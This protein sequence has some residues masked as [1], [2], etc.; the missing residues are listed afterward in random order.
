MACLSI[1]TQ[2]DTFQHGTSPLYV[3]A[4]AF[5]DIRSG[6]YAIRRCDTTELITHGAD[7]LVTY[8]QQS[9]QH[10]WRLNSTGLSQSAVETVLLTVIQTALLDAFKAGQPVPTSVVLW[11]KGA[12]LVRY[13]SAVVLAMSPLPIPVVVKDL[14]DINCPPARRLTSLSPEDGPVT[15]QKELAYARWIDEQNLA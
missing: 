1:V 7:H 11:T 14:E 9:A 6:N 8:L 10:G 3:K 15:V 4:M 5:A 12:N 2:I 13:L